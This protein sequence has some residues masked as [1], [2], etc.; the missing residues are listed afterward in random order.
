MADEETAVEEQ[1]AKSGGMLK[2]IIFG[3]IAVTLL[4]AGIFAGPAV[5]NMISPDEEVEAE[6]AEDDSVANNDPAIYQSLHPPLIINFHDLS[7]N[8]H[9]MQITL[10]VMSRDQEVINAIREH[11]PVI[12]SA[13]ILM[14]GAASYESA[15]TRDGKQKL[16][17][18]A[19]SEIQSVM[20]EQIG[21]SGIEAVYFTSLVIQ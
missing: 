12:R 3:G 5:V 21:D 7:G 16:L 14:F 13:L 20:S 9:Y 17:D 8:S 11:T 1:P 2:M 18:D 10:E 15:V 19:L 6:S 4:A